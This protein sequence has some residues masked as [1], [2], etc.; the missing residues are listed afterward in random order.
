MKCNFVTLVSHVLCSY[1]HVRSL[2]PF[3]NVVAGHIIH[4]YTKQM[5]HKSDVHVVDIL[6]KNE[7]KHSDMIDIVSHQQS[8]I[9]DDFPKGHKLLSGGDQLTCERL[10]GAQRQ[11]MDDDRAREKLSLVEPQVEDWRTLMTF[12]SKV[13]TCTCHHI[14]NTT[15][16]VGIN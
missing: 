6:L 4:P 3:S 11:R 15:V 14:Y 10:V 1:I 2:Q 8:F 7:A 5:A 12:L 16:T 9:A 13:N